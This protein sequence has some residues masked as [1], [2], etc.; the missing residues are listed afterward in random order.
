[1]EKEIL[2]KLSG[3]LASPLKDEADVVYVLVEVRK[4]LDRVDPKANSYP[5]LRTY[6]NW[7][8]HTQLE[9]GA[10]SFLQALNKAFAGSSRE[11]RKNAVDAAISQFSMTEFRA[12]LL[13]F[14]RSNGLPLLL[15]RDSACWGDFLTHYVSVV[16]EC[17]LIYL[18]KDWQPGDE[19]KQV[20]LVTDEL[21]KNIPEKARAKGVEGVVLVWAWRIDFVNGE[22]YWVANA[23]Q[24]KA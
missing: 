10:R 11:T 18:E 19:I 13:R 17:P 21:T 6:C 15:V 16:T 12:E 14:L 7:A 2:N 4:Y 1:L 24:R 5:V 8:V 3:K 22:Q 23:F 9:R 20:T